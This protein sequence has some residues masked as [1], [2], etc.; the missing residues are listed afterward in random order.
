MSAEILNDLNAEQIEAVQQTEGYVRVIAGAGSGKTRVLTRRYT[1]LV[2]D[3]GVSTSNILCVTFTNKAAAEMKSRIRQ[4]IGD[5]DL[6]LI[7]TFH[8]FC[9]QLLRDDIYKIRWAKNFII[10]D[11]DDTKSILKN[12]YAYAKIENKDI[13]Y[14]NALDFISECKRCRRTAE[15]LE[16]LIKTNDTQLLS[17]YDNAVSDWDKI[18]YGYIYEQKK[19][20]GLDFNDLIIIAVYIL[21]TYQDVRAK[22]QNKIEYIMVDEFQ[23]IS[24][25]QYL[26]CQILSDLHKNLFVVGDPD[27]TIYT[28]R[29]ADVNFLLDF[30]KHFKDTKTIIMTKNYRSSP[31]ILNV[32]NALIRKNTYRIDKD[33]TPTLPN[34]VITVYNHAPSIYKEAQ[35]IIEQIK[36]LKAQGVSW[37]S[38]AILYRSH[39]VSRAIEEILLENDIS[40]VIYSGISFYERAEIKDVLSYLRML[41]NAD[42][43]AFLRTVNTPR[44]NIGKKRLEILKNYAKENNCSLYAALQNNLN[45]PLFLT[46]QAANYIDIIEKYKQ[47]YPEQSLTNLLKKLLDESGYEDMLRLQG[48]EERLENLTELKQSITD[49][50]NTSGEDVSLED[51]LAKVALYTNADKS[52]K[53]Q[54]IKMMTVHTAK[55]LEFPYV[56]VCS[57]NEGIFPTRRAD[58]LTKLEEER[59]LAY[60]A[61]TRAQKALFLSDAGGFNYDGSSRYPSRFIFNVDKKYLNYCIELDDKLTHEALNYISTNEKLI[62]SAGSP[63]SLAVGDE[64]KHKRFGK[65]R[66][67]SVDE[68]NN[69]AVI[70]FDNIH[71]ERNISTDKKFITKIT[72]NSNKKSSTSNFPTSNDN[73]SNKPSNVTVT[74]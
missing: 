35:W 5:K 48:E 73:T 53:R 12:V 45:H 40:Y 39:Y 23:D 58:T 41:T 52:D 16:C 67:I 61:F 34:G 46:T 42:D 17:L 1:Y 70:R 10:L 37:N 11:N 44:R 25:S 56:F 54:T 8:S 47:T 22:W 24:K 7:C 43:L 30:D 38:I 18:F 31:E 4:M 74:Q 26:L 29:G 57:L 32:S 71:S 13:S 59:R 14:K 27:Q 9:A 19:C 21:Q 20:Y 33:L 28:W 6:G 62:A 66:V 55:G 2:E 72:A 60:V 64:V 51:Y 68:Q 69:T 36:T 3:F 65:G 15:Y 50:E 49:Y 63:L